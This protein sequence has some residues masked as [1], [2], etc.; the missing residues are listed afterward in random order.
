MSKLPQI[1]VFITL[2]A[3]VGCSDNESNVVSNQSDINKSKVTKPLQTQINNTVYT[4]GVDYRLVSD[5]NSGG[6]T[7]PFI[8]E[9]FWLSCSHCQTLEKPLQDYKNQHPEL[10][11]MRKHAVLSERWVMD[12]RLYYALEETN[13]MKHFDQFFALYMKGMTEERLNSFFSDNNINKDEFF[14]VAGSSETILSQ[15]KES[16]KEMTDNKMTSVPSLVI[17]GKYL[18]L[19]SSDGDYFDLVSYLLTQ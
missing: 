13:N 15:M 3:L 2:L 8:I 11:F 1:S 18:I 6:L 12:A 10:G 4:E 7:P 16:L 19:K 5:I 9:Y 17:N 14:K